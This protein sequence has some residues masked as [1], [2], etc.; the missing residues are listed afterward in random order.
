MR[1]TNEFLPKHATRIIRGRAAWSSGPKASFL[2]SFLPDS[3]SVLRAAFRKIRDAR[4]S[5]HSLTHSVTREEGGE[6]NLVIHRCTQ[7]SLS[8][9]P[10]P[11]CRVR[12]AAISP[13]S[14]S[15]SHPAT[16]TEPGCFRCRGPQCC[17]DVE[18]AAARRVRSAA[19]P[20]LGP[21]VPIL[22]PS[23]VTRELPSFRSCFIRQ[24]KWAQ[25]AF[26]EPYFSKQILFT[27][28]PPQ[29]HP[30]PTKALRFSAPGN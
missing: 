29:S 14:S 28:D 6:Q 26:T 15:H 27:S 7:W 1:T 2:P 18:P 3:R 4:P 10:P 9:S 21:R 13:F 23:L 19:L 16:R 20:A 5:R 8:S 12:I 25:A 17:T 24:C 11:P 30:P 22:P